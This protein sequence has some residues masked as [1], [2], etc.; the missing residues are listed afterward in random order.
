VIHGLAG[1]GHDASWSYAY[2]PA[3]QIRS[4]T[5]DNDAYAWGGHYAVA[6]PYVTNGLNQ[7]SA[8]GSASFAYDA[9]GNLIAEGATAYAYDVENRLVERSGGTVLTYDPLGRLFRV[10][11]NTATT[12]FLYDGD[13]LVA[14]YN[15]LGEMTRRY[16]HSTGADVPLLSYA[17]EDLSLPSYLHA[18]HQGSIVAVSDPWGAGSVNSYDEYGI[19]GAAN[20][21]RFQYTGQI[22]LA[23]IGMY[24]YKARIYSPTLGRFLQTDPV[25]YEDQFNLYAYVRNDPVNGVDPTGSRSCG[26][27]CWEADTMTQGRNV[28]VTD[29]SARAFAVRN[30]GRVHVRDQQ[31]AQNTNEKISAV[32]R[33]GD[34]LRIERLSARG[35]RGREQGD[36]VEA[37]GR[38]VEGTV[39]IM[40]GQGETIVPG[41]RDDS[42]IVQNGLANGIENAGRF[43]ILE[44]QDGRYRY[45][46]EKGSLAPKEGLRDPGDGARIEQRLNEYQRRRAQ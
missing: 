27:H 28:V 31:E 45:T 29:P 14:E 2:N 24:H 34:S 4:A 41:P 23:E 37:R 9:N 30:S 16:V 33:T 39:M 22:W 10:A 32:V 15:G 7:Y 5:R 3:S 18:D 20:V 17:G 1:T 43:G 8:A 46:L 13:A 25:G 36:I 35:V 21:G 44:F 6:R 26:R 12:T 40:H 38:T 11:T 42:S 19:P